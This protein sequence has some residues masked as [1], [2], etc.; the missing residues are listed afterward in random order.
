MIDSMEGQCSMS[1]E[2]NKAVVR[3]FNEAFNKNELIVF[4][5]LLAPNLFDRSFQLKQNITEI[6]KGFPDVHRPIENIIAEGDNVWMYVKGTATHTG[7]YLGIAPTDKK[8]TFS[9]ALPVS[10]T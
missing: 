3:K 6:H 5:D 1:L 4:D 7:E 8:S 2:E 10:L 9:R